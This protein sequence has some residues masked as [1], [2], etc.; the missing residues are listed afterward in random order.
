MRI[1]PEEVSTIIRSE[2]ENIDQDVDI[3]E[4]GQVV[5]VGDSIARVLHGAF[6]PLNLAS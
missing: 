3:S 5:E 1:S 4:V 2:M 6:A